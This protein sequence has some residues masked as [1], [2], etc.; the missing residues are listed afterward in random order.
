MYGEAPAIFA[1]S[2]LPSSMRLNGPTPLFTMI[3]A[4]LSAH[5]RSSSATSEVPPGLNA[6]N[7]T[8][9][10]LNVVGLTA[11]RT[12]F[13]SVHSVMPCS[14]RTLVLVTVP[15]AGVARKKAALLA[16]SS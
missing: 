11:T 3:G 16:V 7:M 2:I 4:A 1:L 15:G 12:P 13:D 5:T 6:R 9:S 10:S 8:S 14:A